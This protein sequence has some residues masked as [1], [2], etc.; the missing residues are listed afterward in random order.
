MP[1]ALVDTSVLLA[2]ADADD[3]HHDTA[4]EI[5]HAMDRGTDRSAV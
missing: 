5:V 3:R 2:F 4:Q 1:V